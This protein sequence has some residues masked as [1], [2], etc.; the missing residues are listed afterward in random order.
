M[1]PFFFFTSFAAAGTYSF[2]LQGLAKSKQELPLEESSN[3]SSMTEEVVTISNSAKHRS[4]SQSKADED[5]CPIC[6]E[7]LGNQKMVFQCGHFTCC[8]C[9]FYAIK[10]WFC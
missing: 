10:G 9:K 3:I 8:K 7:K 1:E 5:T 4:E 2:A 6:Q